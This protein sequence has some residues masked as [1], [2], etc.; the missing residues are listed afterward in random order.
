[1]AQAQVIAVELQASNA[2][3]RLQRAVGGAAAE[4]SL[5][6][7]VTAVPAMPSDTVQISTLEKVQP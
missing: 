3:V 2:R 1:M 6:G 7:A 4:R 5:T